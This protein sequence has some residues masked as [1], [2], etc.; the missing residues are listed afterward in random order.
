MKLLYILICAA[1][2]FCPFNDLSARA[3]SDMASM[4]EIDTVVFNLDQATY[5]SVDGISYIDFPVMLYSEDP[6]VNAV[7]YWFQFDLNKLTYY[8]TTSALSALD[9]YSNF[10]SNN[11]YLSNTSS[12]TSIFKNL[13]ILS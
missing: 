3:C 8:S 4:T 11:Q 7:D 12:T 9:V 6:S 13:V 10:N 2:F 1:L 5:S